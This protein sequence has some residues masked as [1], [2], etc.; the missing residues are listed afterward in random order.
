[1]HEVAI[2]A[3]RELKSYFASP[4]A[5]VFGALFLALIGYLT[6]PD[7]LVHGRPATMQE[8]FSYLPI[9]FV[10]FLPALTMR[11]WA[12]ERK[13]GTIELL[14]T[15]PVTVWQL[16]VGKFAASLVYMA[17]V[18]ALTLGLP[19]TLTIYGG[20]DW[21]P[22]IAAYVGTLLLA[23]AYVS[24]GMFCSS[25]TRDQIVAMLL[26]AVILLGLLLL[27]MAPVQ[28]RLGEALSA[29]PLLVDALTGL[30]PYSYFASIS[31]GVLDSRDIVYYVAFCAF[32]LY[33]NA[34]VLNGR[35]IKG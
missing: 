5:Y 27:G 1:M 26:A 29:V 4:I 15:F 21:G 31:R 19:L 2:I 34:L 10:V 20:L 35:R 32:F 30:S 16:I 14:M 13:L 11:L 8:F 6:A 22:V 12:E 28:L 18:L 9:L 24:V 25:V 33:A 23:G 7:M 17:L 3:R